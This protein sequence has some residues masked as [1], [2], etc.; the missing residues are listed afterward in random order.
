MNQEQQQTEGKN[1]AHIRNGIGD[2]MMRQ[3]CCV[4]NLKKYWERS[5][6]SERDGKKKIEWIFEFEEKNKNWKKNSRNKLY[7][8]M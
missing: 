2:L 8:D 5:E 1:D 4:N 7:I 3:K 6:E